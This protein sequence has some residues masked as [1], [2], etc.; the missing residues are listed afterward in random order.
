MVH[1]ASEA[2]LN[3]LHLIDAQNVVNGHLQNKNNSSKTWIFYGDV[4][5]L[6]PDSVFPTCSIKLE[7]KKQSHSLKHSG[8]RVKQTV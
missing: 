4:F 5:F 7:Y 1:A 3:G 8:Y 2:A 6:N